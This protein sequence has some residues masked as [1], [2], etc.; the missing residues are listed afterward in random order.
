MVF[1]AEQDII[2]AARIRF[3][4]NLR[5]IFLRRKA[6]GLTGQTLESALCYRDKCIM[7]EQLQKN[8]PEEIK[9]DLFLCKNFTENST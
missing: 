7:K 3:E 5:L 8:L 1:Q 4:K 9:Y 2:R 6:L